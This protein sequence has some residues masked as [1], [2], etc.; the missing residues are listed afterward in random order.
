MAGMVCQA[1]S[2]AR[3]PEKSEAPTA[4]PEAAEKPFMVECVRKK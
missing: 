1:A 2:A 4:R 3:A